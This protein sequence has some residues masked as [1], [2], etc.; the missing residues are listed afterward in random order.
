MKTLKLFGIAVALLMAQSITAQNS[1]I[2]DNY[3]D[4]E[5][6]QMVT[7]FRAANA[8]DAFPP[9]KLQQKFQSDFPK[10][11]DVEWETANELYEVEFEVR[12]RDIKALYDKSGNLL[13]VVE[14]I[15]SSALPAVVRNAAEAKYPKY[16]F[17]DVV[18][19]R[20]GTEI[21]Y[22]VEM[23]KSFSDTEV[24]LLIKVDGKIIEEQ[25]DY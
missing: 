17:E 21:V 15:R 6:A 4:S 25:F 20:R 8:R 3:S 1:A 5:I 2:S 16:N 19:I 13:M 11:Y 7:L 23:E 10:A 24:K 14:E 9:S 18:K 12:Y 22:K